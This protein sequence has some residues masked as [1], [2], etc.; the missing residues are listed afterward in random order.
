MPQTRKYG[1]IDSVSGRPTREIDDPKYV[2][3]LLCSC[4]VYFLHFHLRHYGTMST[5]VGESCQLV[6]R[7]RH[8]FWDLINEK[9][10]KTS[11]K[12]TPNKR[13]QTNKKRQQ[14]AVLL[15]HFFSV[16]KKTPDAWNNQRCSSSRWLHYARTSFL[17]LIYPN[18]NYTGLL[19]PFKIV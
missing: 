12:N 10:W 16:E 15:S 3:Y 1:Y 6:F 4:F 5:A 17:T 13:K 8:F 19:E 2:L 11:I 18:D 9:C 7:V 14:I